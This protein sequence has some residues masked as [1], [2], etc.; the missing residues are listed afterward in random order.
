MFKFKDLVYKIK[1]VYIRFNNQH[2]NKTYMNNI[3]NTNMLNKRN[4]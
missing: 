4:T 3:N 2:D 1:K